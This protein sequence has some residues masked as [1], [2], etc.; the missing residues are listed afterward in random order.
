MAARTIGG[1]SRQALHAARLEACIHR[2][3]SPA[4]GSRRCPAISATFSRRTSAGRQQALIARR[5]E[6][7]EP[8]IPDALR[9]LLP[10]RSSTG[11]FPTGRRILENVRAFVTT[12]NGG[13]SGGRHATMNLGPSCRRQHRRGRREPPALRGPCS[14]APPML[15]QAGP[16][17]RPSPRSAVP[18]R[19]FPRRSP[20]PRVARVGPAFPYTI[21]TADCLPVLLADRA[22]RAVGI[23]HA[24]WRGLAAGVVEATIGGARGQS[25]RRDPTMWIAWLGPAIG[26]LALRSGRRRS[27]RLR[28]RRSRTSRR[29]SLRASRQQV[30]R[31]SL[32]AGATSARATPVSNACRAAVSAHTPM[33]TASTR[34][35]A[36][37]SRAGWRRRSGSRARRP[38]HAP[39]V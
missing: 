7:P 21:F 22:G 8:T 36:S 6:V 14:P 17:R 10:R 15:A 18:L 39:C 3:D 19:P 12:R 11:S 16:R 32:C 37:G 13:V 23:A 2:P 28:H 26:P 31:G 30:A 1:F 9:T 38:R 27:R 29:V 4:R 33:S 35:G 20:M 25:R 5:T 34:T 24:G